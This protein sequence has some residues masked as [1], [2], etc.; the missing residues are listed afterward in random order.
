MACAERMVTEVL[1]DVPYLQMVFS[2]PKMLRKHFLFYYALSRVT[3]AT[4]REFL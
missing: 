2:T 3:Y 4:T 1:P